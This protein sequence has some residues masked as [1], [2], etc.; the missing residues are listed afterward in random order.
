M[1]PG[2]IDVNLTFL[3]VSV[4]YVAI[5]LRPFLKGA[6]CLKKAFASSTGRN[7]INIPP[8]LPMVC[9]GEYRKLYPEDGCFNNDVHSV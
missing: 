6:N 4:D 5:F 1:W 8:P 2:V 3:P 9:M 7:L